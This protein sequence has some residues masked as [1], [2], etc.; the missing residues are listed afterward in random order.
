MSTTEVHVKGSESGLLLENGAVWLH[1]YM[2]EECAVQIDKRTESQ[3]QSILCGFK[4]PNVQ[5][6]QHEW[7]RV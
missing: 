3:P 6:W 2:E 5:T 7:F 4:F 1:P